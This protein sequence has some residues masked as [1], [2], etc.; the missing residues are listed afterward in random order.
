MQLDESPLLQLAQK[1]PEAGNAQLRFE[2]AGLLV[3]EGL[4]VMDGEGVTV[5]LEGG[6]HRVMAT[7]FAIVVEEGH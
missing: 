2:R 4:G 1:G 7:L 6:T 5:W 3:G